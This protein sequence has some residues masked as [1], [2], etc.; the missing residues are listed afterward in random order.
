MV[1]ELY[2]G[3]TCKYW[4]NTV[5][6]TSCLMWSL[7]KLKLSTQKSHHFPLKRWQWTASQTPQAVC[8]SLSL[9]SYALYRVWV[10]VKP[11][12]PHES[13]CLCSHCLT[14]SLLPWLQRH[15][16]SRQPLRTWAFEVSSYWFLL[17]V[18]LCSR[19]PA[20]LSSVQCSHHPL[21]ETH[22]SWEDPC[23]RLPF[24]LHSHNRPLMFTLLWVALCLSFHLE[25]SFLFV[26]WISS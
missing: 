19:P 17:S 26:W 13:G 10:D 18:S 23:D 20:M 5:G 2:G 21:R 8:C 25:G 4:G 1:H 3:G 7:D 11:L 14:D 15:S 12:F 9:C 6:D 16:R 22:T 24:L